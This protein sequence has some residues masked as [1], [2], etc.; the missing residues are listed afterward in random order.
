MAL[1]SSY[2]LLK[3]FSNFSGKLI[4]RLWTGETVLAIYVLKFNQVAVKSLAEAKPLLFF[5]AKD[6]FVNNT[7]L[8]IVKMESP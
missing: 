4:D 6:L 3:V 5:T 2:K 1:G 7:A 8:K